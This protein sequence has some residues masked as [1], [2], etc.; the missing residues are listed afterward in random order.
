MDALRISLSMNP[1]ES[2]RTYRSLHPALW[3]DIPNDLF[4]A[5]IDHQLQADPSTFTDR[6]QTLLVFAQKCGLELDQLDP[7]L[8]E[9]ILKAALEV[10]L[11]EV[12][13]GV[14]SYRIGLLNELWETVVRS[15]GESLHAVPLHLRQAWLEFQLR[16]SE[17]IFKQGQE[18]TRCAK[19]AVSVAAQF[20]QQGCGQGVERFLGE[21]LGIE[22]ADMPPEGWDERIEILGQGLAQ[23]IIFPTRTVRE[24]LGRARQAYASHGDLDP[25]NRLTWLV[26]EV[27][28]TL[29]GPDAERA[30]SI[31]GSTTAWIGRLHGT[32]TAT[33]RLKQYTAVA[34]TMKSAPDL[35]VPRVIRLSLGILQSIRLDNSSDDIAH[36]SIAQTGQPR[37]S[38]RAR[39]QHRAPVHNDSWQEM[40]PR[41]GTVSVAKQ[42]AISREAD[43]GVESVDPYRALDAVLTLFERVSIRSTAD[44]HVLVAAITSKLL[45]LLRQDTAHP[46]KRPNAA[47][48]PI[49]E[50]FSRAI[51]VADLI[52]HIDDHLVYLLF[53][54]LCDCLESPTSYILARRMYARAR[55]LDAPYT[56]TDKRSHHTRWRKLFK[57]ALSQ[58]PH[59][60]FNFASRLY[61]DRY[62]DIGSIFRQDYLHM[63]R[64]V[65]ASGSENP[66]KYIL[67]ERHIKDFVHDDPTRRNGFVLALV[68]GLTTRRMG[69]DA[70]YGFHLA[71]RVLGEKTVPEAVYDMVIDV[72]SHT[73]RVAD[74]KRAIAVLDYV[75]V[76]HP[77]VVHYY[78]VVFQGV[79]D[80]PSASRSQPAGVRQAT[81]TALYEHARGRGI[82]HSAYMIE[83]MA[84]VLA[85][86][87][88]VGHAAKVLHTMVDHDRVVPVQLGQQV[89]R[90]LVRED[91]LEEAKGLEK[92]LIRL[93]N[94]TGA[95]LEGF[96][97]TRYLHAEWPAERQED[98]ARRQPEGVQVRDTPKTGSLAKSLDDAF[99]RNKADSS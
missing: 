88:Y 65:G 84:R 79:L 1:D 36:R 67:L 43:Q 14:K 62:V 52:G 21:I 38:I 16:S 57:A 82:R 17:R 15:H 77:R 99:A 66:S 24:V 58:R 25:S 73:A 70:W 60:H 85:E 19:A 92:R 32:D 8:V 94:R 5:L 49:V 37:V 87:G 76:S 20:V 78:E 46:G 12:K 41:T 91:L 34:K 11:P 80:G 22:L 63:V 72:L 4:V 96:V 56:W 10:H 26:G 39:F 45:G 28:P 61:A 90:G 81:L 83:S 93:W 55:A 68:K 74:W 13:R 48:T 18:R 71:L 75:P 50:R 40:A 86:E 23:G 7:H 97:S 9:R 31:L 27:G 6:V 42:P 47:L 35:S 98:T 51:M 53:D 64:A 44:V 3:P 33:G 54:M 30:R 59:A 29:N 89:L 95:D 2:W 69:R